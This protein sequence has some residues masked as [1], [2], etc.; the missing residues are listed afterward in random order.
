MSKLEDEFEFTPGILSALNDLR[1]SSPNILV[2]A[3]CLS[4]PD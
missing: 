4:Y 1:F 3:G 2:E